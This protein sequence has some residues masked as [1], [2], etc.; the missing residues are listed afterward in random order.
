MVSCFTNHK[1]AHFFI[2][3][4]HSF[5]QSHRNKK[6]PTFAKYF[7]FISTY[8]KRAHF[9][10]VQPEP[11]S[12]P[13]RSLPST[14]HPTVKHSSISLNNPTTQQQHHRWEIFYFNFNFL[15]FFFLFFFLTLIISRLTLPFPITASRHRHL[16]RHH[17][18]LSF[19][20]TVFIHRREQI[21]IFFLGRKPFAHTLLPCLD[22]W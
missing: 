3:F 18:S 10:E 12:S 9:F 13:S 22:G 7:S 5:H 21:F 15:F 8:Q 14:R 19:I 16:S 1:P 20:D 17:L 4:P 6:W 2:C 11:I